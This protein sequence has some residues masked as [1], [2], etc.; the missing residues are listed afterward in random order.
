MLP[1]DVHISGKTIKK[2]SLVITEV[3]MFTSRRKFEDCNYGVAGGA[4]ADWKCSTFFDQ[5][6]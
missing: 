6:Q 3:R 5:S 1:R 2:P 4:I